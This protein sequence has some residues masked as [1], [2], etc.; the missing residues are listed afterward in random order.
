MWGGSKFTLGELGFLPPVKWRGRIGRY[1]TVVF[2]QQLRPQ[3][4][5]WHW[6][7]CA[8]RGL[9]ERRI[10]KKF[11]T[12]TLWGTHCANGSQSW[13][14]DLPQVWCSDTSIIDLLQVCFWFPIKRRSSKI[15]R[16]EDDW[17][18]NFDQNVGQFAPCK[19]GPA[20]I[21]CL[22]IFYEFSLGPHCWY[23]ICLLYTSP[24]PRD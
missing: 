4:V 16:S 6:C 10:Y 14:T 20:W 19:K 12:F 24:S 2:L 9:R 23:S 22:W 21:E 11:S 15:Q 7:G 13:G 17:G 18:R 8:R 1:G 3:H 5:V